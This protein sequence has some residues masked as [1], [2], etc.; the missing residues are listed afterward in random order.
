[1]H[2][3]QCIEYDALDVVHR[4][5]CKA[6]SYHILGWNLPTLITYG[7]FNSKQN[8]RSLQWGSSLEGRPS[9]RPPIGKISETNDNP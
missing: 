4:I 2:R 9:T 8:F 7:N 5:Q 1:M 6:F 3:I